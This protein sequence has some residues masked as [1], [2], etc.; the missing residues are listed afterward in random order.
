MH[1]RHICGSFKQERKEMVF[2]VCA[3]M[4]SAAGVVDKSSCLLRLISYPLSAKEFIKICFCWPY[5]GI[6]A[7]YHHFTN[8]DEKCFVYFCSACSCISVLSH[9]DCHEGLFNGTLAWNGLFDVKLIYATNTG[10]LQTKLSWALTF[11]GS[12]CAYFV[13]MSVNHLWL[14][15]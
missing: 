7:I 14:A 10:H 5:Q 9:C 8:H 6:H 3:P 4:N 2:C 1:I 13:S 15:V 11:I 12:S